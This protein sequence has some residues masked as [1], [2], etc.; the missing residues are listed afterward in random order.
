M[1]GPRS[2]CILTIIGCIF[3][4]LQVSGPQDNLGR[5]DETPGYDECN[6]PERPP[7]ALVADDTDCH[8]FYQCVPNGNGGFIPYTH[9]C[10]AGTAFDE[11]V[12][13]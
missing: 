3:T 10:P 7:G 5:D 13:V 6:D 11:S 1:I 12:Q 4:V 8:I 2:I 9:N